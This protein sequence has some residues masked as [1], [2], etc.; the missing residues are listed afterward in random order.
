MQENRQEHVAV[1]F[2]VWSSFQY[3]THT[4]SY[5]LLLEYGDYKKFFEHHNVKGASNTHLV[6]LGVIEGL[7]MLKRPAEI[8]VYSNPLFGITHIYNGNGMLRNKAKNK[9]NFE[10][11]EIIRNLLQTGNHHMI[12]IYDEYAKQKLMDQKIL[13]H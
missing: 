12:N 3:A 4:G 9:V 8:T 2:Y 10:D 1:N 5:Y 7:N 11:K 13:Y 6:L